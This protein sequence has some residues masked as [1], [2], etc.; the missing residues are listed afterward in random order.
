MSLLLV[1][2]IFWGTDINKQ[3]YQIRF[4][5]NADSNFQGGKWPNND[6]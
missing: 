1:D 6:H 4:K 5:K 3:N 2:R